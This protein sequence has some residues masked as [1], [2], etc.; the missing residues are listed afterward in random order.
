MRED[1]GVPANMMPSDARISSTQGGIESICKKTL[2]TIFFILIYTMFFAC[3]IICCIRMQ[4]SVV[5][6]SSVDTESNLTYR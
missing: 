4:A 5:E 2:E 3:K 1:G 6:S